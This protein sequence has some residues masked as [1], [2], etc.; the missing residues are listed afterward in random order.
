MSNI[1]FHRRRM[2]AVPT[3]LLLDPTISI[4]AKAFAGNITSIIMSDNNTVNA[5]LNDFFLIKLPPS[6]RA[7]LICLTETHFFMVANAK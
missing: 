1:T 7:P 3:N 5:L 4:E 2:T 6:F